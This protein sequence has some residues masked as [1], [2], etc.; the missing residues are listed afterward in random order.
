MKQVVDQTGAQLV[1]GRDADVL[2]ELRKKFYSDV[3][4]SRE[5]CKAPRSGG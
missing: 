3:R 5:R 2:A 1:Y 4:P